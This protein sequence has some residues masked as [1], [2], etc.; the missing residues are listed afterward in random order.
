M[1]KNKDLTIEETFSLAIQN[2]S[3]NKIEDAQELYNQVLELNPNHLDAH[4]NIGIILQ[5]AGQYQKAIKCFEKAIE[6]DPNYKN[7]YNNLGSA[8][9]DLQEYQKAIKYFEKA[10]EIDPNYLDAYN[11]LGGVHGNLE[12][13]QKAIKCFE[14]VIEIDPNY[15][16]SQINLGN[17][18]KN[19]KEFKKAVSCYEKA[20]I[21]NPN[22]ANT[23]FNLG[24][25]F[26]ETGFNQKAINSYQNTLQIDPNFI[27]AYF[28]L[29]IIFQKTGETQKAIDCYQKAIE[30][31]PKYANAHN[32]LGS[33]FG[34]LK[35]YQKAIKCFE[36]VIEIDPTHTDAHNNLGNKFRDLQEYQ[37]AIKCFEKVIEIDPNF[38]EA[39]NN[40]GITYAALGDYQKA[41]YCFEKVIEI[42][43]AYASAHN[44]LG[45]A[46]MNLQEYEKAISCYEK[47]IEIDPRAAYIYSN[48][49]ITF[50]TIEKNEKAIKC[51]EKAI[52]INP[53][54]VHAL[55][56]L[57]EAFNEMG[58]TQSALDC[59]NKAIKVNPNSVDS[60][61]NLS[62]LIKTIE[63]DYKLEADRTRFKE[64]ILFLFRKK[65][66]RH[67]S[68]FHLAMKIFDNEEY[69][70]Q[71]Q[72]IDYSNFLSSTNEYIQKLLNEELLH[73]MLQ[74]TLITSQYL[75]KLLT[76]IRCEILATL[77][78]ANKNILKGY[79]DFIISLAEQCWLNEYI[80]IQ[81]EKEI[82]QI[83]Q[84]KN[85]IVNNKEINELEVAILGCY[86]PLN[87]LKNIKDQLLDYKTKNILF[88][89]LISLQI[90][91]P[92]RETK[93]IESIE[94]LGEI[95]DPISKKV[96]EQYEEHPY[97]KWRHTHAN[98][99]HNFL[100]LLNEIIDP[101]KVG[102]N[103]KFESPNI[104]IAGC[105]TGTESIGSIIYKNSNIL[106]IDLSLPSLAYAKRKT[107][108]L[109]IKNLKYLHADILQLKKLDQKFD[110]I[111]CAGVLHHMSDPIAGLKVL[112]DI[113][114]PHGFLRLGLYSELA[115][116]DVVKAREFIKN[117][118][119][120]NTNEEIR[121]CRQDII[122]KKV[123]PLF[124][125]LTS[126]SDFY[127]TSTT[128]DL[129]FH[130]Q[131]HRFTIPEIKKILNA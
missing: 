79:L 3:K 83:N 8:F 118:N 76:K 2:H 15:L 1:Y 27:A 10:I 39:Y 98:L 85:K 22:Y 82:N 55:F 71:V 59:Y 40:L 127:S 116:Q 17:I 6:I 7:A 115:R 101:N 73:L 26:R 70:H 58:K 121:T 63:I 91:E 30:I 36:K 96:Q 87:S 88:N 35:E 54:L 89:D 94:S 109:G 95:F 97:P 99:P 130:V 56:N 110:V 119:Y 64:L 48:L 32:N 93:L 12:E 90:K 49:G 62:I 42:N 50:R 111:E 21:I 33:M 122:N 113:L 16:I 23:H 128:R 5:N 4:N 9:K 44:D 11:N 20:L 45:N 60:I 103:N 57:G 13:Y 37:K 114:E 117:K 72:E 105:G 84:L 51:Y 77:E 29:A 43:P 74:K 28:N 61:N 106:G 129:L 18:F 46:F 14:K 52:E 81:S 108:E 78:S 102:Y 80:Y 120:K 24:I 107:E 68:I 131:E 67:A 100:Y 25:V 34:D 104:L 38:V 126:R 41:K 124:Q 123:E 53:N 86:M 92:L 19:L 66:I 112:L 125:R 47:A 31:N 69:A 75:E 65:D